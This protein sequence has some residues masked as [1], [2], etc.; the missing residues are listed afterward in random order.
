MDRALNIFTWAMVAA[1]CWMLFKSHPVGVAL[2]CSL[3]IVLFTA[4]SYVDDKGD[5]W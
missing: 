1:L 5:G 4:F 2:P 3:V